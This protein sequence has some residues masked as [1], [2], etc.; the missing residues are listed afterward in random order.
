MPRSTLATLL[1][2]ALILAGCTA[3]LVWG[4]NNLPNLHMGIHGWIALVLGTVLSL[5]LGGGLSAVLVISRRRG[6]DE[7]AHQVFQNTPADID[8]EN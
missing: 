5:V 7:A 1:T 3:F 8:P 4:L 2:A 6:F